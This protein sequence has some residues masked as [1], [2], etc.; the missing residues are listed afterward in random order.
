M[1]GYSF[2]I[3]LLPFV[4]APGAN[5]II[6][7]TIGAQRSFKKALPF[8]IGVNLGLL[9]YIILGLNLSD[10]LDSFLNNY[11]EVV[12]WIGAFYIFYLAFNVWKSKNKQNSTDWLPSFKDGIVLGLINYKAF[13]GFV[14]AYNFWLSTYGSFLNNDIY[15][16]SISMLIL[17][18][19]G[20]LT[21]L[22]LGFFISKSSF[23]QKIQA[24]I[25]VLLLTGVGV[26]FLTL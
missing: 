17:S 5:N 20:H 13:Y 8:L 24:Y 16:F 10:L 9:I 2:L 21:W 3:F 7:S 11:K 12:K 15:F 18:I 25:S 14:L 22:T 23:I 4:L 19:F 1:K 26:W 6:F